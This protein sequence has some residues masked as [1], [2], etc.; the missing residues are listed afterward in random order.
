[1]TTILVDCHKD[2][3]HKDIP[4]DIWTT[5]KDHVYIGR[6]NYQIQISSK[7]RNKP[8][9]KPITPTKL[10]RSLEGYRNR[11]ESNPE[12]MSLLHEL[13][14][15]VL[16]CWCVGEKPMDYVREN[17]VCHGSIIRIIIKVAY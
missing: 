7:W 1:M 3:Y 5:S 11:V 2:Y 14:G 16:G 8:I 6:W 10:Q 15:K 13:R 17:K 12:L 4:Y 9:D